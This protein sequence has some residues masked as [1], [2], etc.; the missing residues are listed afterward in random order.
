[1]A[2][3]RPGEEAYIWVWDNQVQG[4]KYKTGNEKAEAD[5]GQWTI[6]LRPYLRNDYRERAIILKSVCQAY[7]K[8]RRAGF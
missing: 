3:L 2:L 4:N 1:M 7:C 6:N 8:A 5:L